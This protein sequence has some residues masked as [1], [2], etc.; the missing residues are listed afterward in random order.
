MSF[1]LKNKGVFFGLIS[2]AAFLLF[3][4]FPSLGDFIYRNFIFQIFRLIWD[5]SV[6]LL[7]FPLIYVVFLA[8]PFVLFF[9]V[10]K[11][12]RTKWSF[13]LIP[14]NLL[15]W[16]LTLFLWMWGFNYACSRVAKQTQEA[17]MATSDLYEFGKIIASETNDAKGNLVIG[18]TVIA[19]EM[20]K[21]I[22]NSNNVPGYS[23]LVISISPLDERLVESIGRSVQAELKQRDVICL[24]HPRVF[25][26]GHYGLMRKWGI[27]GIYFPFSGQAQVDG[28]FLHPI[29][30]FV[31]AHE[32]SH[33]NG[34]SSEAEADYIAYM[35]LIHLDD[36]D[37][38]NDSLARYSA[39][40]ELLRSIRYQLKMQNDSLRMRIDS[41]IS[42]QVHMDIALIKADAM[43]YQEFFPGMQENM[44]DKYLKIMG[45]SSGVKS[46]DAF[47]EMI[48]AERRK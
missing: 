27:A 26:I 17:H 35:S 20:L 3:E 7:P 39:Q 30:M 37:S 4:L 6:S 44:N 33:A 41:L 1:L 18:D 24:G 12:E 8:V 25:E 11:S 48:W 47:V 16:T 2:I 21:Y 42:P 23:N 10:K 36:P 31:M 19:D 22:A 14:L 40:L 34:V 32:L 45:D 5:H 38:M 9:Y 28:S 29:K 15:F 43:T 46:Y 13:I